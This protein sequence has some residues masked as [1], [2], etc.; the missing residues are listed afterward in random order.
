MAKGQHTKAR[1]WREFIA[2]FCTHFRRRTLESKERE[3]ATASDAPPYVEVQAP[4]ESVWKSDWLRWE[5]TTRSGAAAANVSP[6]ERDAPGALE[7]KARVQLEEP[8]TIACTSPMGV[9]EEPEPL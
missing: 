3:E 6:L 4:E 7:P 9:G 2:S 8:L 1:I 5:S